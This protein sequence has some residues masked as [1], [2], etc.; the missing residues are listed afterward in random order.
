MTQYPQHEGEPRRDAKGKVDPDL[1]DLLPE[2]L[3]R[4][5][6]DTNQL[7]DDLK[8]SD[9]AALART[10]HNYK[11]SAG[12]FGMNELA[13]LATALEIAAKAGDRES[14]QRILGRWRA[15]VNGL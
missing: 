11:G 2:F 12:Y 5:R 6:Q 8:A 15:A 3:T 4:L 7:G 9:Y 14:I 10:A 13:R 1:A